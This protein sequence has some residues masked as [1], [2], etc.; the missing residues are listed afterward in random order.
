MNTRM[1]SSRKS[2]LR[3]V[4][5]RP[6]RRILK[7]DGQNDDYAAR[8]DAA[9]SSIPPLL[10]PIHLLSVGRLHPEPNHRILERDPAH[11]PSPY[12][13]LS[14]S[15]FCLRAEGVTERLEGG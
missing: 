14:L 15:V 6:D 13:D 2:A 3:W 7:W 5:A 8:T 4:H 12:S 10:H 1:M 9:V 11:H